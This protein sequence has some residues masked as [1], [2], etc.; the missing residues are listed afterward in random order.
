L[1]Q[2]A[3]IHLILA[4]FSALIF[5][6]CMTA[7]LTV[8]NPTMGLD[9]LVWYGMILSALVFLPSVWAYNWARRE[10]EEERA[11]DRA[12]RVERLRPV[13]R[14]VVRD[15]YGQGRQPRWPRR[16]HFTGDLVPGLKEPPEYHPHRS[17]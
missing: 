15:R 6:V 3:R 14:Q 4:C 16:L 9:H 11:R 13:A 2:N 8:V 7:A 1:Q 17:R 10:L 5:V 12:D